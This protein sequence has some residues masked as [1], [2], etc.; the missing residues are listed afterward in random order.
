M[1]IKITG[2]IVFTLCKNQSVA[3]LSCDE[4]SSSLLEV[5]PRPTDHKRFAQDWCISSH[6]VDMSFITSLSVKP[7]IL[8]AA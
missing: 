2:T 7:F 6:K 1:K 4:E 8:L 3:V 5:R